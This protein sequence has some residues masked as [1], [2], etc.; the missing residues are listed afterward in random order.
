PNPVQLGAMVNGLRSI[1]SGLSPSTV[2]VVNGL[3]RIRP[4]APVTPQVVDMFTLQPISATAPLPS[5]TSPTQG[6]L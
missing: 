5:T 3:M 6:T 1:T 2:V 4:G